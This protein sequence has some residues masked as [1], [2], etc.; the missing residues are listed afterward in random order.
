MSG[1][2]KIA[3]IDWDITKNIYNCVG[4]NHNSVIKNMP[5]YLGILPY[6]LYVLPGMF[7]SILSLLYYENTGLINFHLF[8]HIFAFTLS[9]ILKQNIGRTRPG[10]KGQGIT[11][12]EDP[13]Y[14][15]T[16]AKES[17]PSG[18]AT[19][20]VCMATALALYLR[21]DRAK[22]KLFDKIDFDDRVVQNITILLSYLIC[23]FVCLHRITNGYH[24]F[25]DII[26]GVFL[27]LILGFI[28]H[29]A[30][31]RLQYGIDN[32]KDNSDNLEKVNRIIKVAGVFI[33]V[34]GLAQFIQTEVWKVADKKF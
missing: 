31:T 1:L 28:S 20:S 10:C 11:I 8:P 18:H 3:D 9:K 16:Y 25:G 30:T 34:L 19:I 13:L 2:E 22:G 24:F 29:R 23:F 33:C 5:Y 17:F 4:N 7:I 27:G 14:C 32:T 6:Q 12:R 21:S 15:K 26:A